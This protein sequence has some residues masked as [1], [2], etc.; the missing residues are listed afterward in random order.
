MQTGS[1]G[2]SELVAQIAPKSQCTTIVNYEA[3]L[4]PDLASQ[5]SSRGPVDDAH[6]EHHILRA[7]RLF[8]QH[9][10]KTDIDSASVAIVETAG[11]VLSPLPSGNLQAD[12]Y[13][14][15]R[16]PSVL[17][18]D[19]RLGG[20]SA[21]LASYEALRLRGYTVPTIV[22]F[23]E[24]EAAF[25]NE[26]AILRSV[27]TDYTTV[28][29][30]PDLPPNEVKLE[31]YFEHDDV[32]TFFHSLV[33]HLRAIQKEESQS[34]EMMS[35]KAKKLIWY[36]F[37]QHQKMNDLVCIDSAHED[38]LKIFHPQATAMV[39]VT[40][41]FGSWWTTGVG[42]GDPRVARAIAHAAGRY[43]HVALPGAIHE[44]AFRIAQMLTDG[45]GK[46]WASRV[47]FSDNGS[48]AVE[49]ALKMAFRK[50]KVDQ[51]IDGKKMEVAAIEGCYHGDTLGVM[52]CAPASDFNVNQTPWYEPRGIF[53]NPPTVAIVDGLWNVIMPEEMMQNDDDLANAYG[54]CFVS[55]DA[56]FDK[57]RTG[58][59]YDKYIE[60]EM[61]EY[62]EKKQNV[63]LAAVVIEP[64]MMG[65][66]GMILVDPAFQ[67][68]LVRVARKRDMVVVFDEVFTGFWRLGAQSA[69]EIL[70]VD[71]DIAAYAKLLTGGTL[72]LSVT[73]AT[74]D[75]FNAFLSDDTRDALLHGHSYTAHPIGCAA[76]VESLKMF[77]S[78]KLRHSTEGCIQ[79]WD[80]SL[81]KE[82][83]CAPNVVS[84]VEMGTVLAVEIEPEGG[85]GYAATG[86]I[87]LQE[88]LME[89]G[90]MTRPLGNVLYVMVPPLTDKET[91]QRLGSVLLK[92]IGDYPKRVRKNRKPEQQEPEEDMELEDT[93]DDGETKKEHKL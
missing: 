12:F 25:E 21:T 15:F 88:R 8:E 3:P 44:N 1:P 70:D 18:G 53:F 58:D 22:L 57:S 77:E 82:L 26:H 34:I 64:V 30:A 19:A 43:G 51:K 7:A 20:I 83:S 74:E 63:D 59:V 84:V 31:K 13:R 61:D 28:L 11:G 49:V 71:P 86:S 24:H 66:G 90:V 32:G 62:L 69:A 14:R 65:A 36:P 33:N 85:T 72:P 60:S 47:F 92:T 79:Y 91:C 9:L 17:V 16:L 52:D 40:D 48:T 68:A 78:L 39:D 89:Q 4:S 67:R 35:E 45:V 6:L 29:R 38:K 87:V 55:R 42:H 80:D 50:R 2:D 10:L 27:N 76:A 81:A 56:V 23:P 75:V 73:L 46:G 93:E 5:L 41:A 54:E 37:T